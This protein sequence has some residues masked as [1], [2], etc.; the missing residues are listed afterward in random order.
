MAEKLADVQVKW[1][2]AALKVLL[3]QTDE[4]VWKPWIPASFAVAEIRA[5]AG[6][7]GQAASG[8]LRALLTVGLAARSET[9]KGL[10]WRP[11]D[12]AVRS[13]VL[14]MAEF[15]DEL[16]RATQAEAERDEAVKRVAEVRALKM[17]DR[18][19]AMLRAE[20][21]HLVESAE[22]RAN[23]AEHSLATLRASLDRVIGEL[24]G[25]AASTKR[26]AERERG[27][28]TS[29]QA[30]RLDGRTIALREAASLLRSTTD[31]EG[32]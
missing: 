29:Q 16:S 15:K 13:Q 17:D 28:I 1:Q 23:S 30:A 31:Q 18:D 8:A 22:Q 9:A 27:A 14:L 5:E 10:F 3:T 6:C 32:E 7:S 2:G 24:E 12:A 21:K 25:R 4:M 26:H 20:C 19:A 11:T